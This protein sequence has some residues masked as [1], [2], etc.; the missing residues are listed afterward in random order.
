MRSAFPDVSDAGGPGERRTAGQGMREA[1]GLIEEPRNKLRPRIHGTTAREIGVAILAGTYPPGFLF[2]GEIEQ[3]E[4]LGISRTAYREAIRIL[5]AK[6]LVESRPKAGTKVNPTHRWNLL[7]PDVLAWHFEGEPSQK[8]IRDLFELRAVIEPAAVDLA[9][10]RREQR[11]LDA[12]RD[13]LA[14]M[15]SHGIA[16]E[17]WQ[18]ADQRFHRA[19]LDATDNDTFRALA[20][21]VGAAVSWSTKFKTRARSVPRD[22]VADHERVYEAIAASDPALARR[23]M[24]DLLDLALKD[25]GLEGLKRADGGGRS[26]GGR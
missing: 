25:M 10:R 2:Q 23:T 15:R 16:S 9:A 8:F 19:I 26:K 6:G 1:D 3:S 12:M 22:A 4:R 5:A 14:V 21:S 18:A 13:A 7:D 11:H 17:A 24:D 20:T